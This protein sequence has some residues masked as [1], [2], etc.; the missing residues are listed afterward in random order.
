[1]HAWADSYFDI[2]PEVYS[3]V[4]LRELGA[5]RLETVL[6]RPE[7]N[8]TIIS[9]TRNITNIEYRNERA[10]NAGPDF[11]LVSRVS[12]RPIPRLRLETRQDVELDPAHIHADALRPMV[13]GNTLR[14][15]AP[16]INVAAQATPQH[17]A[18]RLTSV[19]VNRGWAGVPQ[20]SKL[21]AQ[22]RESGPKAPASLPAQ[23]K[24]DRAALART[25]SGT[26]ATSTTRTAQPAT[27]TA[28]TTEKL[29]SGRETNPAVTTPGKPEP[30]R[31]ETGRA[32]STRPETGRAARE[33]TTAA[34]GTTAT[35]STSGE[36]AGKTPGM[37][38]TG[39]R[40]G[41]TP[42]VTTPGESNVRERKGGVGAP[43]ERGGNTETAKP[44]ERVTTPRTEPEHMTQPRTVSPAEERT[45]GEGRPHG[46]TAVPNAE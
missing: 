21:R 4:E 12:A 13:A 3:F 40:P 8:V 11:A 44:G 37:P 20:A 19:Q 7:E 17:L 36:R 38:E 35:P 18:K 41:K 24:F 43:S 25:Q 26:P 15:V 10:F 45:R 16:R 29:P 6:V 23:P 14:V 2:G 39:E 28:A 32:E 46:E 1:V 30:G 31:T 34:P 33:G 42:N 5:P 22:L 9:E 27:G